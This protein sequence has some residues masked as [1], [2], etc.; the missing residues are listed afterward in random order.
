MNEQKIVRGDIFYVEKSPTMYATGSEMYAGRPGIVISNDAANATQQTVQVVY[1]T[2][3]PKVD[4]PTHVVVRRLRHN[5]VALMEQIFTVSKERLRDYVGR[6]SEAELRMIDAA[7]L[8]QF[9]IE[10]QTPLTAKIAPVIPDDALQLRTERDLY[11]KLY[12]ELIAKMIRKVRL[13]DKGNNAE[14][15][16]D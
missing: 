11:K 3:Q 8:V 16:G 5:S 2:M 15:K 13:Y 4:L 10:D 9:G 14:R 1:L 12:D 6:I 7:L